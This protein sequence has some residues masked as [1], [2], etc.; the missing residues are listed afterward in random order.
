MT[1]IWSVS[2]Q[3]GHNLIAVAAALTEYFQLPLLSLRRLWTSV[4]AQSSER[5][6]VLMLCV[7]WCWNSVR[8]AFLLERSLCWWNPVRP[9]VSLSRQTPSFVFM[10]SQRPELFGLDLFR[11]TRKKC[12]LQRTWLIGRFQRYD[13]TKY[14]NTARSEGDIWR[15]PPDHR[16]VVLCNSDANVDVFVF[17]SAWYKT[18]FS[19]NNP[20]DIGVWLYFADSLTE[21]C[22]GRPDCNECWIV[23]KLWLS[24]R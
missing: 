9:R 6:C 8:L 22:V 11:M 3:T 24:L 10:H 5:I 7:I 2:V 23:I 15:C 13:Q 4:F 17:R 12:G 20:G 1:Y 14:W 18:T 21:L 19:T 16:L